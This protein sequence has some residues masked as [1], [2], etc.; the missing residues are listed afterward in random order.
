MASQARD[1]SHDE[2]VD[3]I[4][5]RDKSRGEAF[6]QEIS[7]LLHTS[8][9]A[10]VVVEFMARIIASALHLRP[11]IA[12]YHHVRRKYHPLGNLGKWM[13]SEDASLRQSVPCCIGVG[14][15]SCLTVNIYRF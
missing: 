8:F 12:V 5:S 6:W 10:L 4:F 3:L 14:Y 11:I 13:A 9:L 2:L 1:L 15:G 7:K